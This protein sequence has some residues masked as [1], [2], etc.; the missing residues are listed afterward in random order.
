[1]T[2]KVKIC[3]ITRLEDALAA[4]EA[5]ADYL[6]F[7]LYEKSPRYI[8]PERLR[9]LT[10]RLPESCRKVGVFVNAPADHIRAVMRECDLNVVQLHGDETAEFAA[11]LKMEG[12]WKACHLTD[13]SQ[14]ATLEGFPADV[15]VIDSSTPQAR[16]GTGLRCDWNLAAGAACRWRVMLAGGI[17]GDNAADAVRAVRPYGLDVA[18]GVEAAPGIKDHEKIKKLFNNLKQAGLR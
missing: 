18:S 5:G 15:L 9:E 7:I 14:L 1:M 11:G 4:L 12:I 16:G 2:V 8:A 17:N 3:G 6:G 13:A 10:A